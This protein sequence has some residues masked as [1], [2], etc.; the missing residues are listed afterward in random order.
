MPLSL[1]PAPLYEGTG[2][3]AGFTFLVPIV[4][5]PQADWTPTDPGTIT[6]TVLE[7]DGASPVTFTYGVGG[8]IVRV[9]TGIY[10]SVFD[11]TGKP[12]RWQFKWIGTA[13]CPTVW[14]GGVVVQPQPF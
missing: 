6:L 2:L 12:G 4:G 14:V 8:Q 11:T 10:T 3:A 9:S 5:L 1:L 7:G 13:P